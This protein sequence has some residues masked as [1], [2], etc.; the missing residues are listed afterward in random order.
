M[1]GISIPN[2]QALEDLVR[3]RTG[4]LEQ[5]RDQADTANRAKS[6]FLAN[7]SHE[8]RTPINGIVGAAQILDK[9]EMPPQQREFVNM[10]LE[11]SSLLLD[12]V[13]DILDISKV[14]AGKLELEPISFDLYTS[15]ET[16]VDM[17]RQRIDEKNLD[18]ILRFPPE[19]RS[20][21]YGDPGRIRQIL[22]NFLSNAIKFTEKGQIFLNITCQEVQG[23]NV[24]LRFEVKDT[25]I[26]IAKEKQQWIFEKFSQ[27]DASTTRRYGGTGL[28]LAI[29]KRLTDLMGGT[30]GV[31]S[32]KGKGSTFWFEVNLQ[33]DQENKLNVQYAEDF[34]GLSALVIED[35]P[36]N[37]VIYRELFKNWNIQA[38]FF[39]SF[40]DCIN[41]LRS[42]GE[43]R[44][45][46]I[47]IMDFFMPI[48]DS[49]KLIESFHHIEATKNTQWMLVTSHAEVGD[50]IRSEKSGFSG[51]LRKPFKH[52]DLYDAIAMLWHHKES[53][54]D[55]PVPF[56]TRH[57]LAEYRNLEIDRFEK[58][59]LSEAMKVLLVED[60]PFNQKVAAY[61]LRSLGMVVD[62]ANDGRE[63]VDKA[64]KT[65]YD[66]IFMDC[67][68]PIMSGYEATMEIR[69][70]EDRSNP[71]VIIAM[72][73]HVTP[74]DR[75]QCL[76]AGM[77]D[78]MAKPIKEERLIEVLHSIDRLR[79]TC[80][81]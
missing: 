36:L 35:N 18:F 12:L 81:L 57:S 9:M 59:H 16:L 71:N 43:D 41:E 69:A 44:K 30:I 7:V 14:E 23:E 80:S 60:H 72:T 74:Q 63:G 65:K 25:G 20:Y 1:S 48:T 51:Y 53:G 58:R 46:D 49:N 32:E 68:M 61:A 19:I 2:L 50:R 24:K 26:G 75:N 34:S 67:Q 31:V 33:L 42:E 40:Y 77:N 76:E 52:M 4:E 21:V 56:I 8:I 62:I 17:V 39:Q 3:Q 47:G 78:H 10:I 6:E 13:N 66:V 15:V 79:K 45:F 64:L 37:R 38:T 54:E 27:E 70:R 55:K 11:S 29:C 22:L 73:A 28:G 5:A